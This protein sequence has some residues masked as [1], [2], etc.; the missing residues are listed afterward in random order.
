D[1]AATL[2]TPR[3]LD[4]QVA[5]DAGKVPFLT[6]TN[7][8]AQGEELCAVT[9]LGPT[10]PQPTVLTIAGTL[11]GQPYRRTIP[12][13]DIAPKAGYL[14]RTWAK[15]EI[16][17]L[18]ASLSRSSPASAKDDIIALSKSMYVMTPFTSL[19]VLENEQMYE[20]FKVDR[21]RKDHWAMYPCPDKI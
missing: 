21:G 14:P 13:R 6:Y 4:I 9:R 18:V 17:R 12:V 7:S 1:L 8:L 15:L 20:Q 16:D 5:D 3:L 10:D 2:N 19:L 11:D